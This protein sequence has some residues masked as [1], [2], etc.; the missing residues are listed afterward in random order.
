M[1]IYLKNVSPLPVFF[2]PRFDLKRAEKIRVYKILL[3]EKNVFTK[4]RNRFT[5]FT[6]RQK[7]AILNS[8]VLISM[9][10]CHFSL[11]QK[12]PISYCPYVR[13]IWPIWHNREIGIGNFQDRKI[14]KNAYF[15]K[16]G[17]FS[18]VRI[19]VRYFYL[20]DQV[21]ENQRILPPWISIFFKFQRFSSRGLEILENLRMNG[22]IKFY[23]EI[24]LKRENSRIASLSR[25]CCIGEFSIPKNI[26]LY[27]LCIIYI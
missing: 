10:S 25:S 6:I 15:L 24:S 20:R 12:L 22:K 19:S 11:D 16:I 8:H 18:N 5:S 27:I 1:K 4:L 9:K 3:L 23:Q 21:Y 26:I 14:P 17:N 13:A 7:Q 2:L